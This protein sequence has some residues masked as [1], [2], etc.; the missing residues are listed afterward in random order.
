MLYSLKTLAKELNISRDKL[1]NLLKYFGIQPTL[2]KPYNRRIAKYFSEEIKDFLIKELSSNKNWKN[3]FRK[4]YYEDNPEKKKRAIENFKQSMIAKYGVDNPSK[5]K[6]IQEKKINTFNE[7]HNGLTKSQ[8][9]KEVSNNLY[10]SGY[11]RERIISKYGSYE[12]YQKQRNES[13]NA[14]IISKYGSLEN[15]RKNVKTKWQK[16]LQEKYG[17]EVK[18][19]SQISGVP[20]M[21]VEK[22]RKKLEKE[23]LVLKKTLN[24]CLEYLGKH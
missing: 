8:Y 13:Y 19:P 11:I 16:T 12:D 6:E 5:V 2:E 24:E 4:Q 22:R 18:N 23:G 14:T 20:T 9:M 1:K 17:S 10:K 7:N 15:F 3:I 21:V